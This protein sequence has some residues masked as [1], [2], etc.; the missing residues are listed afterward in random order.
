M[1]PARPSIEIL[2]PARR[3]ADQLA[4]RVV[5]VMI[6]HGVREA[7]ASIIAQ[8]A[9]EV[10]RR[11]LRRGAPPARLGDPAGPWRGRPCRPAVRGVLITTL[12]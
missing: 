9:D 6:G 4:T 7:A 3:L 8:G 11:P 12:S 2:A 5:A 1:T 10:I